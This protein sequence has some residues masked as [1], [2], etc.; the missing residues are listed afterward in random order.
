MPMAS[1]STSRSKPAL[2]KALA[3]IP[4]QFR[5]KI[6]KPFLD[7]K[8]RMAEGKDESAGLAAGKLCE[9]ALRL[10]QNEVHGC[11]TPFGQP[12][13]NFPDECRKLIASP[14]K[15]VTESLRV[16]MPR[17]LVFIYTLRNKRGIG[18]A[19]G[20]VDAN[21][22]DSMTIARACDWVMCELIRVYHNLSLEEA[23]DLVDSLAQ[24]NIPDIWN[25]A[26]KKRVLKEGLNFKEKVLLLCYSD[27]ENTMFAEDLFSWVEHS[28]QTVFNSKILMAL[29]KERLIEY[30]RAGDLV[31][32]SPKGIREVEERILRPREV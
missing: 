13:S 18:H 3:K 1:T 14:N 16:V 30:D 27:A 28:N 15:S 10:L 7:L 8:N 23:Q 21:R 4:A 25:I 19:G 6:T 22:I 32:I 29:H 5:S 12:I 2:E 24:R 11:F 20:D 26:G 17:G 9:A 31:T